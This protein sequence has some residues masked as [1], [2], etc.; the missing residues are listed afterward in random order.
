MPIF[1][2]CQDSSSSS[3][4]SS[5]LP[6]EL[7]EYLK[8][9]DI[10]TRIV[11]INDDEDSNEDDNDNT[12]E[13]NNDRT[14]DNNED[15]NEDN[16]D[17]GDSDD[18]NDE[19]MNELIDEN[20]FL[21]LLK[22]FARHCLNENDKVENKQKIEQFINIH[23]EKLK[24]KKLL[25]KYPGQKQILIQLLPK[26][27]TTVIKKF[28]EVFGAENLEYFKRVVRFFPD[29]GEVHCVFNPSCFQD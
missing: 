26:Y 7:I 2:K 17:S 18:L 29:E 9:L 8:N 5:S 25:K 21:S 16:E 20:E 22:V 3:S 11:V 14:N 10:N 27:N 24:E 6:D 13:D 4:S 15:N 28:I 12:N 1:N 19:E 23:L